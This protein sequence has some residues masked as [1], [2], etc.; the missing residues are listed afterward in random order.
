MFQISFINKQIMTQRSL[1]W[2]W[3]ISPHLL[4]LS[5]IQPVT[6][7]TYFG[8]SWPLNKRKLGRKLVFDIFL[9]SIK[10]PS[11]AIKCAKCIKKIRWIIFSMQA[12]TNAIDRRTETAPK[13]SWAV[14]FSI[15]TTRLIK[16]FKMAQTRCF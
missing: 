16:S 9:E 13:G 8:L 6:L 5:R 14:R 7:A 15:F 11:M 1:F 3:P 12:E 2:A 4:F 10:V